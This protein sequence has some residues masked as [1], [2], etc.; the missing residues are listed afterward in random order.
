MNCQL[1]FQLYMTSLLSPGDEPPSL[2]QSERVLPASSK[3]R[4]Y[5]TLCCPTVCPTV[6]DFLAQNV[7]SAHV[8]K[9]SPVS[10]KKTRLYFLLRKQEA[11]WPR[12]VR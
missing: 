11:D 3:D 6:K 10:P 5:S 12:V 2:S 9:A 8:E 1:S 4:W 7:S